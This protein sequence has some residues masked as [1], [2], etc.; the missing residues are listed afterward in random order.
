MLTGVNNCLT[1]LLFL[2]FRLIFFLFAITRSVC[3]QICDAYHGKEIVPS[4][5]CRQKSK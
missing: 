2:L 3:Q 1:L 5:A 4:A